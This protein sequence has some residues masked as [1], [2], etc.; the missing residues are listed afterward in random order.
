MTTRTFGKFSRAM[1]MLQFIVTA[2]AILLSW[3]L[4]PAA[5]SVGR[6]GCVADRGNSCIPYAGAMMGA[7]GAFMQSLNR[8][9][10]NAND[11]RRDAVGPD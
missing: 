4:A 11:P 1:S 5:Q 10:N 2:T 3:P 6:S 7:Y 9:L 8:E